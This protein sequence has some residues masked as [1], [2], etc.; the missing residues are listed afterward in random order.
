MACLEA[1]NPRQS[2]SRFVARLPANRPCPN[3][4]RAGVVL[5]DNMQPPLSFAGGQLGREGGLGCSPHSCWPASGHYDGRPCRISPYGLECARS[6]YCLQTLVDLTGSRNGGVIAGADT[7]AKRRLNDTAL[8][9]ASIPVAE[10]GDS[11]I[12]IETKL[13]DPGGYDQSGVTEGRSVELRIDRGPDAKRRRRRRL[14]LVGR[15]GQ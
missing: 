10:P 11:R 7:P 8:G 4:S 13:A 9:Y 1:I 5:P 15:T 3:R 12:R 2:R 6:C 14:R